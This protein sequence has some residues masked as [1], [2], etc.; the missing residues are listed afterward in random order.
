[1]N[2]IARRLTLPFVGFVVAGS[3]ALVGWLG[4][5]EVRQ[6]RE[7]F[8]A[9]ARTNAEF[10][11]KQNLPPSERTAAALSDVL[12]V[13]VEFAAAGLPPASAGSGP[14]AAV[15]STL[16]RTAPGEVKM[17]EGI[18][19][20]EVVSLPVENGASMYLFRDAPSGRTFLSRPRTLLTLGVFWA[21]SAALAWVLA[22]GIVRPLR[23]F[24]ARLPRI[25]EEGAEPIPEAQ[26]EDE[27]G[28]L[29]RAYAETRAQLTA[30]RTAREQ[31]ERLATL[32]KMATG[33]AHE[34]NNPV[35]AIKLHAQLLE[36]EVGDAPPERLEIILSETAKIESL[37]SQWMF[38]ARPQPPHTAPC[39][40]AVLV[41]G[42]VRSLQPAAAHA[43][44]KIENRVA[45]GA[46]VTVDH[47]R[48]AQAITNA[49]VNAIHAMA[50]S[51]GAVAVSAAAEGEFVHLI[52]SDT[53]PGFSPE[54][55]AHATELFYSEK[56]GGMGI[57][58]SVTS[59]ILR[60]HGGTLTLANGLHGGAIVT[61]SLPSSMTAPA[62]TT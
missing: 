30:E 5:E 28:Q 57:G 35:A 49:L 41:A 29:A 50:G 7:L 14:A 23:S 62:P 45:G 11:R 47:R 18:G 44:V 8:K 31:A 55:L 3:L 6:S 38:L 53:G 27:I 60:A 26:R 42:C 40:V 39:E 15:L 1:M 24:A 2:S 33:L 43:R 61:M 54:A 16:A 58:L 9:M 56:E 59:E 32:G 20:E 12:G 25:A 51:G 4:A 10:I 34:I 21:L 37:V 13:R 22:R 52:F 17:V 48:L 46:T 36:T 19:E